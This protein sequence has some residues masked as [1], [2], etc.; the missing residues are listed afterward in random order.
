MAPAHVPGFARRFLLLSLGALPG[1]IDSEGVGPPPSGDI[2]KETVITPG[3][4]VL[5]TKYWRVDITGD[6]TEIPAS[7]LPQE[8]RVIVTHRTTAGPAP[9]LT[10]PT[11]PAVAEP[12][13]VALFAGGRVP[14]EATASTRAALAF[15]GEPMITG[16]T[17]TAART[18]HAMAELAGERVLI[19]GGYGPGIPSPVLSS[20]EIFTLSSRSFVL[21]GSMG[22]AR[23]NHAMAALRDG[24]VLVTGGLV[25]GTG[26]GTVDVAT[27]EIFSPATGSFTAGPTMSVARYGHSAITLTD[28]RVLVLGGW[29]R[30]SAEVYTPATNA[31][32]PVSDMAVV[33]GVGHVALL[34][35]SGKV[36]VLGGDL[37]NINPTAIAEVFDP[38]SN[39]FTTVGSMGSPR[40]Q[41]FAVLLDDGRVYLGGGR[42]AGGQAL[43][44]AEFFNPT[45][46]QF[47]PAPDLPAETYDALAAFV[48]KPS[49]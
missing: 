14:G 7:Q 13:R 31:F 25:P 24:R 9:D 19:T 16:L 44:S 3:G 27:T 38:A 37:G 36:L 17:M 43:R 12:E 1:C 34:L 33:H 46:G 26:G 22:Q 21:T 47:S 42:G 49:G 30:R 18:G 45:S 32:T 41:H 28:G 5:A 8:G 39:T 35:P 11:L 2:L 29:S 48:R 10:A 40:M 4:S 20:A 15:A 6:A 23:A